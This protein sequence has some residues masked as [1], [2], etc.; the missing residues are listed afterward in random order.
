[1]ADQL[2]SERFEKFEIECFSAFFSY[3]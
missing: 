1:M 3:S 2:E